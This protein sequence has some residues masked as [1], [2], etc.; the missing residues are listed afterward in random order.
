MPGSE[1]R[2]PHGYTTT[3]QCLDA[4]NV[5]RREQTEANEI[6]FALTDFLG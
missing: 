6:L 3:A 1:K 5:R 4:Y 2:C